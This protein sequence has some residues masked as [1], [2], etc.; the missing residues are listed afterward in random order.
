MSGD[1]YTVKGNGNNIGSNTDSLEEGGDEGFFVYKE[2][3][4]SHSLQ[5]RI[6]W[7]DAWDTSEVGVMI[8][9]FPEQPGSNYFQ[10]ETNQ[11]GAQT[12]ANFRN[13]LGVGGTSG[14]QLFTPDGAPVEDPGDG[15]WIRATRIEPIDFFYC[16]YSLDG[17]EWVFGYSMTQAW[18][19][20]TAAFGLAIAGGQ[21][22]DW[23]V[24]AKAT[25]VA[26]STPPPITV[27]SLSQAAFSAGDTVEV[28][29]DVINPGD[30]SRDITIEETVPLA[31][32]VSDISDGGSESGGTITWNLTA[33]PAGTTQITYNVTAP[34][35]P[36]DEAFWSGGVEGSNVKTL[37]KAGLLFSEGGGERV[38]DGILVLYTFD[39]GQGDTVY[40]V[41]GVGEPLNLKMR[42]PDRVV[43]EDGFIRVTAPTIIDAVAK[44]RGYGFQPS[45]TS[46]GLGGGKRN[47]RVCSGF[48]PK[49]W[50]RFRGG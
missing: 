25:D 9:Q 17:T 47:E 27:R 29:I 30:S 11:W 42:D 1:E 39:A 14:E 35:S 45:Y 31:W 6:A 33:V 15:L 23:L 41:S 43:W 20:E 8:R 5:A 24:E 48:S 18:D 34:G 21:D 19:S 40:D 12:H 10:I 2:L 37:G 50:G 13:R 49:D 28:T 32:S 3:E 7:I 16:E 44:S 46:P 22:D 36:D 4:G 38:S 26:F